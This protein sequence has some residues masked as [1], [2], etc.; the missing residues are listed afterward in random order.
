MP[1]VPVGGR[2][3]PGQRSTVGG[4]GTRRGGRGRKPL[5]ETPSREGSASLGEGV[6]QGRAQDGSEQAADATG[7]R[8]AAAPLGGRAYFRVDLAQPTHGQRLR[9]T[10]LGGRGVHP[11]A[12]DTAHGEEACTS[13]SI[14]RQSLPETQFPRTPLSGSSLL[15][16]VTSCPAR[17]ASESPRPPRLGLLS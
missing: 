8:E 14:F 7:F 3:L 13:M 4:A 10:V 9:A 5:P 17:P 2:G 11:R 16:R 6:V 1:F 15:S 12:Y